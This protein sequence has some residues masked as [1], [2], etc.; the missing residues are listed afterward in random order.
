VK[1]TIPEGWYQLGGECV[2]R[3]CGS[4]FLI[5]RD[6]MGL[7]MDAYVVY[8]VRML[9]RMAGLFRSR[10]G[11]GQQLPYSALMCNR[12]TAASVLI[13]SYAK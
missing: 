12:S 7:F 2:N 1:R 6:R 11:T 13:M 10:D 5:A 3:T 4:E 9:W 8:L